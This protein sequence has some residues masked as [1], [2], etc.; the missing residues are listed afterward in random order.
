M[1]AHLRF[2]PVLRYLVETPE[3]MYRSPNRAGLST[4]RE[5]WA[6]PGLQFHLYRD[7]AEY[8]RSVDRIVKLRVSAH[9]EPVRKSNRPDLSHVPQSGRDA[10]AQG[11]CTKSNP[12][13][14]LSVMAMLWI[15]DWWRANADSFADHI[16]VMLEPSRDFQAGWGARDVHYDGYQDDEVERG[17]VRAHWDR[18]IRTG[19]PNG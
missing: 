13:E 6:D 9:R 16:G 4:G 1:S 7:A 10:F 17:H 19:D 18:Y 15:S 12:H 14:P 3:G 2:A 5:A 8:A 11:W